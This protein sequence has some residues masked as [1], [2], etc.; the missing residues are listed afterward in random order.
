MYVHV[1]VY[2]CMCVCMCMWGIWF[3]NTDYSMIEKG[4]TDLKKTLEAMK[5]K[6][7]PGGE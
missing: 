4:E 5:V 7:V 1:P 3:E 6:G 2:L